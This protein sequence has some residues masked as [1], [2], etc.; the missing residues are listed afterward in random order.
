[1]GTSF[2]G[3]ALPPRGDERS[4]CRRVIY[5]T[6]TEEDGRYPFLPWGGS[7]GCAARQ[8]NFRPRGPTEGKKGCNNGNAS[9]PVLPCAVRG[10]EFHPR[11]AAL[12]RDAAIAHQRDPRAGA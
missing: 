11:R 5:I 10:I 8:T 3:S 6:R 1:M 4:S 12:R 7:D 2:L 9:D